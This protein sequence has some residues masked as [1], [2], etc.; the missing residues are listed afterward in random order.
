MIYK[1]KHSASLPYQKILD[2]HHSSL[3]LAANAFYLFI[4]YNSH[5]TIR[6][7]AASNLQ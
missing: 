2:V 4:A 6:K 7:P 3:S 5:R 1:L